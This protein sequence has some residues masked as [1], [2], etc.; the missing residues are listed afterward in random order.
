MR[1]EELHPDVR[2]LFARIQEGL[3]LVESQPVVTVRTRSFVSR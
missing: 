1:S 3:G 2:M